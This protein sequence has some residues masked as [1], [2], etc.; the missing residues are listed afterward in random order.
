MRKTPWSMATPVI[1]HCGITEQSPGTLIPR[2]W[3][4]SVMDFDLWVILAGRAE[5]RSPDG[6]S[7]ALSRGSCLWLAPGIEYDFEILE[8]GLTTAWVH[9]DLQNTQGEILNPHRVAIPQPHAEPLNSSMLE[10]V[11]RH[12]ILSY[13]EYREGNSQS[14]RLAMMAIAH[15][16]KGL[17]GEFELAQ[18]RQK[19]F[20]AL[21]ISRH[22]QEI[23]AKSLSWIYFGA[24]N[25]SLTPS[26]VASKFGYSLKHFSRI[27]R[28][29][30]GKTPSQTII[31]ARIDC[32][33]EMLANSSFNIGEIADKLYYENAFYFSKQFKKITGKSPT[34]YRTG[35]EK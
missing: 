14:T 26:G 29:I 20:L 4:A 9:F 10:Q 12:I 32:A 16:L 11:I 18:T 34:Q 17:L 25:E 22:H 27:F 30:T 35:L 3:F 31:E 1:K 2:K 24:P 19:A 33:K 5:A 23:I 13:Y 21:G 7:I 8:N 15:L 28:E 6:D